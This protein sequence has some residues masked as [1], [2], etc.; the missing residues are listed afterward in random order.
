MISLLGHERKIAKEKSNSGAEPIHCLAHGVDVLYVVAKAAGT[1]A[2]AFFLF[3]YFLEQ[4]AGFVQLGL[5]YH[6]L[7]ASQGRCPDRNEGGGGLVFQ[8]AVNAGFLQA[9][10]YNVC[11]YVIG[12]RLNRNKTHGTGKRK[13]SETIILLQDKPTQHRFLRFAD[14]GA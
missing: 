2:I 14:S 4:I 12:E 6:Q 7:N 9:A 10:Q 13:L 8:P 3:R 5:Q 11:V 1:Q